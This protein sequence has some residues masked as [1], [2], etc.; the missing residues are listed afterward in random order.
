[1]TEENRAL[2]EKE[3]CANCGRPQKDHRLANYADGPFVGEGVLICHTAI[4][5]SRR[6]RQTRL[7]KAVPK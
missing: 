2:R 5:E 3:E 4:Y 7:K 1:M 6:A